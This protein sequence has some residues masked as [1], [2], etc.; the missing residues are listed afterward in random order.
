[1]NEA[2]KR[3]RVK[4]ALL[5]LAPV[6]GGAQGG[7]RA[8]ISRKARPRGRGRGALGRERVTFTAMRLNG[9]KT[10][11]GVAMLVAARPSIT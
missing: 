2:I 10:A 11:C 7:N 8:K 9:V 4:V 6:L 1:M 3:I 5:L